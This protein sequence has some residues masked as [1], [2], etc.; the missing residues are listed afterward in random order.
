MLLLVALVASVANLTPRFISTLARWEVC[1]LKPY[2]DT[3]GTWHIG[4]GHGN[5]NS[6][7]PFVD[8]NTRLKDE[9]EAMAILLGELNEV[10][11]PQL[12]SAF[13]EIDFKPNDFQHNACLDVL[14]NRGFGTF[15]HS[16]C[17]D[18]LMHPQEKGYLA[19]AA[20]AMVNSNVQGFAPLNVAAD[21]D[22]GI[23]RIYLGLT[24]RRIDDAAMF[25]TVV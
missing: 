25:Q 13:K 17:Y 14:Y 21:R 15:T 19:H 9:A 23:P 11:V 16:K 22:T 5:A 6:F 3:D 12:D 20:E 24:C 7:A 2:K 10:Y 1:K 18:W 4:Y 8:E